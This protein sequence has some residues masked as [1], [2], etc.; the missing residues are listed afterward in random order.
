MSSSTNKKQ[1]IRDYMRQHDVKWTEAARAVSSPRYYGIV[2]LDDEN[3]VMV[4]GEY[5]EAINPCTESGPCRLPIEVKDSMSTNPLSVFALVVQ[6]LAQGEMGY[7]DS[8]GNEVN[9]EL[10]DFEVVEY[11]ERD[12]ELV[13][14]RKAPLPD[15][16]VNAIHHAQL[17]D[18]EVQWYRWQSAPGAR[19]YAA[20][21]F[22]APEPELLAAVGRLESAVEQWCGVFCDMLVLGSD[23]CPYECAALLGRHL[24]AA[25]IWSQRDYDMLTFTHRITR[26]PVHPDDPALP[27]VTKS[28]ETED[29]WWAAFDE[30]CG[31]V[32][33]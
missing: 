10:S 15:T 19:T 9:V 5:V 29:E 7:E 22:I 28:L 11:I 6:E 18:R 24:I 13:Q 33:A 25:G 20:A 27:V 1:R 23:Q 30:H 4:D 17:L 8:D 21:S 31:G 2:F 12:G 32:D 26:G 14:D 16:V 3:E